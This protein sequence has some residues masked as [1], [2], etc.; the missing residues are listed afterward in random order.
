MTERRILLGSFDL[1]H[2]GHIDQ[3]ASLVEPGVEVI[4]GV[5]S[6]QAVADWV[7]GPPFTPAHE[8]AAV[9]G[10]V[11][12]VADVFIVGPETAWAIPDHDVLFVD[13]SLFERFRSANL[14][15]AV[16]GVPLTR[17]PDHP[18]FATALTANRVA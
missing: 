9:L 1:L 14:A 18:A 2:I 10:C 11:R 12:N 15:D 3:I 17:V 7:G 6:D 16:A 8:R 4:V 13:E 5:L